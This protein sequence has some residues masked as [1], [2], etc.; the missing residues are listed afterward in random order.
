MDRD[1]LEQILAATGRPASDADRVTVAGA[2]PVLPSGYA[3]GTAA[4]AAVAAVS[5]AAADGPVVVDRTHAAVAFRSERY[6][7]VD[8][9]APVVWDPLTADYRAADGV[10]RLHCNY[11]EHR[12]AALR[13]LGLDRELDRTPLDGAAA[14]DLDARVVPAVAAAVRRR[15]AI[16]V[17]SAVHA[18]GGAAAALRTPEQWRDHPQGRAVA[19]EPLIAVERIADGAVDRLTDGPG[20]NP[21][22]VLDLTRV[23]AG[24]V[25]GRTLAAHGADVL[26]VGADHLALVAP[27]VIDTGFGKRFTHLDL[28]TPGGR[29]RLLAL[30]RDAD[31]LIQAYR[32]GALDRLGLSPT[33]LAEVN[34]RLGY[35][36]VNAW[37]HTGPWAAR[38]GFDSL[39]QL[40][41]G[42]AQPNGPDALTTPLPAQ[43]LDHATGWLAA[44]AALETVRRHRA[45]GGAWHARLSLARTAAWLDG[46]GRVAPDAPEPDPARYLS[47]MDSPFGR[48][49]YVRP[50]NAADYPSPP[51]RPGADPPTWVR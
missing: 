51:H 26:R 28:R 30:V 49:T 19:A 43:V 5:L 34:P 17:E 29:D 50:P 48:L 11:P 46:L 36:S 33:A 42:I 4:A 20:G 14:G 8:G 13:A 47:T 22:R 44:Y 2:E 27:L 18:A 23:I 45:R 10:V 3:V 24:P 37:G 31:V 15:T 6:L 21:I 35:V 7:R 1:A 32:P 41:T 25:A 39:V 9:G 12:T 40:A 38:R 16:D